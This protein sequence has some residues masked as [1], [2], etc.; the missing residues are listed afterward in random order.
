MTG[1]YKITNP[2]GK[3]Y[4]GQSVNAVERLS[5]YERLDCKEQPK[6]Y[7]S[8]KKYG[9]EKHLFEVV[10]YCAVSDLNKLERYY[11]ELY[12]VINNGLNCRLTKD[13][14]RS[15]FFSKETKIKMS[16]SQKGRIVSKESKLKMSNSRK[17]QRLGRDNFFY[18]KKHSEES[19]LKMSK[20]RKGKRIGLENNTS[21]IILD[22]QNGVFYYSV[23]DLSKS[24]IYSKSY[25]S[26]MLRGK[27]PNK[28]QF[29]YV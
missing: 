10:C 15:G 24:S 23:N 26:E 9:V 7:N 16:I 11:Q 13:N 20:L 27:K 19:K 12:D 28:T 1:I 4:I 29:I 22:L 25:L 6:I 5:H 3:I 17:G 2:K 14:D 21:N 18:G 8:L